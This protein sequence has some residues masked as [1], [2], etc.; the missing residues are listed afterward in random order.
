MFFRK[1][2]PLNNFIIKYIMENNKFSESKYQA[3]L[4]TWE[5]MKP[6][7]DEDSIPPIPKVLPKDYKEVIIPNIIRC[8]G[9]PK[10]KL[11]KGA[12][13]IGDCRNSSQA[14]WN[15]KEFIYVREKFGSSY[16]E[17]INHFEDVNGYD[18]F[19][20][21]KIKYNTLGEALMDSRNELEKTVNSFWN[22]LR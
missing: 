17:K 12:T 13:Y 9:I 7:E 19:V 18:V 6:F 14:L 1:R 15:G 5:N 8:G 4:D 10:D 20:P 3:I 2:Y 16:T 21:I 22:S 11:K